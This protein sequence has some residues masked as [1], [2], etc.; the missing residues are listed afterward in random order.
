MGVQMK[1]GFTFYYFSDQNPFKK[2]FGNLPLIILLSKKGSRPPLI[3]RSDF[4]SPFSL[5][6][7][8][9]YYPYYKIQARNYNIISYH[10]VLMTNFK[11]LVKDSKLWST[12][13]SNIQIISP[14]STSFISFFFNKAQL[15][16]EF[17]LD[18]IENS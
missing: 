7:R 12:T 9:I 13:C 8:R 5:S 3:L 16:L 4:A 18:N 14:W 1:K 15:L 17:P 2:W 6:L 10:S 11:T